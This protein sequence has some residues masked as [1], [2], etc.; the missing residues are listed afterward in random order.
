MV[1]YES[2]V[3][4]GLVGDLR[5]LVVEGMTGVNDRR[6][7]IQNPLQLR[8]SIVEDSKLPAALALPKGPLVG[9]VELR[10][11]PKAAAVPSVAVVRR[12]VVANPQSCFVVV[13]VAA[14]AAAADHRC[15]LR[16]PAR[17]FQSL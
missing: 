12:L 15:L 6:G 3:A 7:E 2:P 8:G 5:W 1:L 16:S 13:V 10:R 17:L 9:C 14:A 4:V 11:Y